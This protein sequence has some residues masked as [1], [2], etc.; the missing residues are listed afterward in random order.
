MSRKAKYPHLK[1][2]FYTDRNAY[3]REWRKLNP[4]YN[5]VKDEWRKLDKNI[6]EELPTD[7]I[8]IDDFPTYYA[9]PNGEV[10][11][12]TRGKESAVKTGKERVLKLTPTYNQ[13]THY[14]SVQPYKK[15][16]K[17]TAVLLHRVILKAFK[18]QAPLPKME[19]HHIDHNTSN[20]SADNLMWVTR[21]EN[22]DLVPRHHRT[23]P[24]KTLATGRAFSNSRWSSVYSQVLELLNLGL[25]PVDI[26]TKLNIPSSSIYEVINKAKSR[27]N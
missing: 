23:V 24:K 2:L 3:M 1:E 25:R 17:K 10:W 12:D 15:D 16:G 8:P 11:R 27:G 21:Q 9:R 26:A 19:C 18:G 13:Y 6:F 14:W 5:K 4:K 20:N 22:C 7:V